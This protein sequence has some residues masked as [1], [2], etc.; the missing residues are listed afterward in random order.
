M[1][2]GYARGAYD[3][4]AVDLRQVADLGITRDLPLGRILLRHAQPFGGAYLRCDRQ[5]PFDQAL[6]P[7]SGRQHVTA[8]QVDQ[9]PGEAIADRTPGV[10]LDE[11]VR[12][13]RD[14]LALVERAG[15]SGRQRDTEGSE[16]LR[17]RKV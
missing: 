8:L 13:V 4:L 15:D 5:N 12:L 3:E 2:S 11:A 1:G 7:C 17:F 9:V 10:L 16:G 14:G 6:D